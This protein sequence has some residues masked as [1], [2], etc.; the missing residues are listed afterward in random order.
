MNGPPLAHISWSR[1]PNLSKHDYRRAVCT[2][3]ANALNSILAEGRLP[4]EAMNYKGIP[5]RKPVPPQESSPNWA[6]PETLYRF[7]LMSPLLTKIL[8]LCLDARLVHYFTKNQLVDLSSQGASVP[9][10]S[11]EYHVHALLSTMVQAKHAGKALYLVFIDWKRAYDN[12]SSDVLTAILE[13]LGVPEPIT[14]LLHYWA[15]HRTTTLHVNGEHSAPIPTAAGVGQGDVFSCVLYNAFIGSLGRFLKSRGIGVKPLPGSGYTL[16]LL[17]FVDDGLALT[18]SAEEAQRALRAIQEWGLAFGH[19]LNLKPHKTCVMWVP[20]IGRPATAQG[21]SVQ[22]A[23]GLADITMADGSQVT[24]VS[25]YKYL[26]VSIHADV[27]ETLRGYLDKLIADIKGNH[28]RY[29]GFNSLLDSMPPTAVRQFL[30]TVSVPSYLLSLIT[31]SA[32]NLKALDTALN[33]LRRTAITGLRHLPSSV[34]SL[35]TATESGIP[36]ATFL[37]ARAFLTQLLGATSTRHHAAPATQLLRREVAMYT[38]NEP[39]PPNSWL[40]GVLAFLNRYRVALLQTV[41]AQARFENINSLLLRHPNAPV[42]PDKITLAARLFATMYS[43]HH[44][45]ELCRAEGLS[46]NITHLSHTPQPATPK[47]YYFDLLL[48]LHHAV[49]SASSPTRATA[50][51]CFAPGGAGVLV[52]SVT[53]PINPRHIA[54]LTSLRLGPL[55]L[56]FIGPAKWTLL[57]TE[58]N[59]ARIRLASHGAPCPLCTSGKVAHAYHLTG[60]CDHPVLLAVQQA[61]KNAAT[62]FIPTLSDTILRASLGAP[63]SLPRVMAHHILTTHP[64]PPDFDSPTGRHFLFRLLMGLPYPAAAVDDPSAIHCRALGTLMDHTTVRNSRRHEIANLWVGWASKTM[65]NVT[66]VWSDLVDALPAET[67]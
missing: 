18:S 61:L 38:N 9:H 30:M 34:P 42:Y 23:N 26:G 36:T 27:K 1:H 5:L 63:P 51:S 10:L 16:T 62:A 54:V 33:P 49:K 39:L 46:S 47:Q 37:L 19:Q 66:K 3:I 24:Y 22:E 65:F 13:R 43:I 20:P 64:S 50:L 4:P 28:K 55:S 41:G 12:V 45:K 35:F 58:K 56:A 7:I 40:K 11:T 44:F 14:N 52:P 60:E 8:C 48:C 59:Q 57:P 2:H 53:R 17:Q 25:S 21:V 32:A 6:A 67:N 29:F 15:T 31:P